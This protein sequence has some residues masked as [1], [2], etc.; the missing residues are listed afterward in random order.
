MATVRG[1]RAVGEQKKKLSRICVHWVY[2]RED[3][4]A[5]THTGPA[6]VP[7]MAHTGPPSTPTKRPEF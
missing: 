7:V 2:C 4:G 6:L 1:V 3:G 5:E